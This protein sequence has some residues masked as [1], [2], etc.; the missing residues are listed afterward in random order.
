LIE[1]LEAFLARRLGRGDRHP[2]QMPVRL[3]LMACLVHDR[4]R[5]LQDFVGSNTALLI[6]AA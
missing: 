1:V 4:A 6:I 2:D 5:V 3:D